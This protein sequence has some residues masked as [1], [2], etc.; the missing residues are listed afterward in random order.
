[1]TIKD[2]NQKMMIYFMPIF[3]LVLFNNFPSGLVL[4]WTCQVLLG[5]VQQYYTDKR[6]ESCGFRKDRSAIECKKEVIHDK[7]MRYG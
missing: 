4:Y 1:M 6:K 5:L 2:P 3:M 7:A